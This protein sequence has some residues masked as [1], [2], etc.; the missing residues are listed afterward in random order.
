MPIM[1]VS[2]ISSRKSISQH[3]RKCL[4]FLLPS[5]LQTGLPTYTRLNTAKPLQPT[6]WIDGMR[7]IAA[8]LVFVYH[9]AYST[10]DVN[11]AWLADG[12][13]D[14]LRLPLIRFFYHGPF[15]VSIF[16]VLSG[17]ALSYKPVQQI[18]KGDVEAL[19]KGLAS[20]V[21]RRGFRLY[22]PCLVSTLCIV[23]LVRLGCYD[24]TRELASD[25]IRLTGHR[26][27]HAWRYETF[28]EQMLVWSSAFAGFVNPFSGEGI[29]VDTHLWTITVEYRAS[30]IL[31]VTQLGLG[32]LRTRYRM[33]TLLCLM[34]WA[35]GVDRWEMVLFYG[36]FILAEL[37]IRRNTSTPLNP[38]SKSKIPWTAIY[39]LTFVCGLYLGGQPE[40][41][42]EH[43][44]GWTFLYSIIPSYIKDWYRYYSGWGSLLLI[45]STS[46]SSLLQE[47]FTNRI[48]QYLGRISFS[49][50]LVHGAIIHTLHYGLLEIL[51]S[52]I[53]TETHLKKEIAFGVSA[54]CVTAT[55]IWAADVFTRGVDGPS[56]R[57]A[58]WLEGRLVTRVQEKEEPAWR[59]AEM[60]V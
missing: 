12:K 44:P 17:Y 20:A 29:N 48:S 42:F 32:A 15:M 34:I 37:D 59:E 30:I 40:R 60:I 1:K 58:R 13:R 22:M 55:S 14:F 54:V 19:G 50:Y 4:H 26:E 43:A 47:I 46:N 23:V 6:A 18:K 7:G 2:N 3:T 36:G 52:I 28:G 11:T 24:K 53:G 45:W 51:W 41:E 39:I 25:E 33:L 57:F 31:Y 5:F 35:H 21:L 10:H 16:F 56:V 8:F 38:A 9:L 49:L 27:K